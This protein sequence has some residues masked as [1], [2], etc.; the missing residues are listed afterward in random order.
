MKREIWYNNLMEFR[1]AAEP[2]PSNLK[3]D[4]M[5]EIHGA[6]REPPE[7]MCERNDLPTHAVASLGRACERLGIEEWNLPKVNIVFTPSVN[8]HGLAKVDMKASGIEI[9]F[10]DR[11]RTTEGERAFMRELHGSGINFPGTAQTLV[12][13]LGHIALWS[14]TGMDRQPA[15]R[16]VDEGWASLLE[17]VGKDEKID[18][19]TVIRETKEEVRRG[20]AAEPAAYERCFDFQRVVTQEDEL[21]AAEYSVGRA[22][23]LWILETYDAQSFRAFL[24][25]PISCV[26]RSADGEREGNFE[27]AA[28]DWRI[29]GREAA[30]SYAKLV[31][32]SSAS[33][34]D[35]LQRKA[36]QWEGDQLGRA[37][38]R[39]TGLPSV[40]EV[41]AAF[42]KWLEQ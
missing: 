6:R 26:R 17:H 41:Q 5:G 2:P 33:S 35:E 4:R 24:Q 42:R 1:E 28:V 19:S 37:L 23:L 39:V 3:G 27:E 29:H 18:V 31:A 12:H 10:D 36:L 8:M 20:M 30:D 22:L 13:E 40:D 14:V 32:S 9:V 21:N 34:P 25:Q 38:L 11:F 15:T 7:I 16:L